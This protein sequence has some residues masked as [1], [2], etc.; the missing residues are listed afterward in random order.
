MPSFDVITARRHATKRRA[1]AAAVAVVT[2]AW[3]A[4]GCGD[5]PALGRQAAA[6]RAQTRPEAAAVQHVSDGLRDAMVQAVASATDADVVR[7]YSPAPAPFWIEQG[8]LGSDGRDALA[9]L[10]GAAGEGLEPAD[11][12]TTRLETWAATTGAPDATLAS[13]DVAL[14]R[15]MLRYLRDV[16]LGRVNPAVLGFRLRLPPDAHDFVD[17]L[18]AARAAHRLKAVAAEMRPA[19]GQYDALHTMLVRYRALAVSEPDP[20]PEPAKGVRPG[21]SYSG[22]SALSARLA[23]LGDLPPEGATSA[24][25]TTY[26]HSVADAVARFQRRHGLD[27]DGVLGARTI[28]ELN[29][30][31]AW[32]A[33]QIALALERLRWLPDLGDEPLIAINIPMFHLWGWDAT[34]GRQAPSLDMAVIVGRAA[35]SETPIIDDAL[36]SVI[37]RPFWNVPRSILRNEILPAIAR[38]AGYLDRENMEVVDGVTDAATPVAVTDAALARL[39]EGTLRVRQRPGPRNALGLVK[40]VFPNPDDIYMHATPAQALFARSRRDFSHGCVRVER[41]AALAE[42]VLRQLPDWTPDR[43]AGAMNGS[44]T[45]EVRLP[46]PIRVILFYTT[47][48]VMS[49]DGTVHFAEDIYGRDRAL[50]AALQSARRR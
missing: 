41:P 40:F 27:A 45:V 34:P 8:T 48:A 36:R 32:R 14:S 29:V 13:L 11:Y 28:R 25:E 38:D 12:D 35:R 49:A 5:S 4:A 1:R 19:L 37:F 18:R 47:A 24:G 33:R 16:H 21:D 39:R 3:I 44:R 9:L 17:V 50:D 26:A 23:A 7:I 31:L 15:G 43:I 42:W 6:E 2:A 30:P 20:L 22:M 10:G 46:Q